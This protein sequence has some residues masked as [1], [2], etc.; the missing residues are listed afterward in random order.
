M[1]IDSDHIISLLEKEIE[2]LPERKNEC[3]QHLFE[4]GY[5]PMGIIN[6]VQQINIDKAKKQFINEAKSSGLYPVTE[7]Y[8]TLFEDDDETL[9]NLLRKATDIDEGFI[10]DKLPGDGEINL[11]SRIIHYR[12]DVFGMWDNPID[13]PYSSVVTNPALKIIAD[14]IKG[15]ILEAINHLADIQKLTKH[16]LTIYPIDTFIL[17]FKPLNKIKEEVLKSFRGTGAFRNQLRA[18]FGE[19]N[20]FFKFLKG[21][22]FN[23]QSKNI[24]FGFLDNECNNSLKQ[25]L[26]RLIQ[27]HQWQDGF[28]DGLLDSDIGEL[29]LQSFIDAVEVYNKT[30]ENDI[31]IQRVITHVGEGYFLFN[32]LFFLRE[33]MIEEVHDKVA[34]D[35]ID[36]ET[37]L[38]NSLLKNLYQSPEDRIV[39]FQ[40]GLE[41]LKNDIFNDS[42]AEPTEKKGLLK[43]IYFGFKRLIRKIAKI[44]KNV[45]NWIIDIAKKVWKVL[46]AVFGSFFEKLKQGIKAFIDGIKFLFGRREIITKDEDSVIASRMRIDGDSFTIA[47]GDIKSSLKKHLG[48]WDYGISSLRFSMAIV[49]GVLKIII[50]AISIISWPLILITIVK[51][52]KNI[53]EAYTEFQAISI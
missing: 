10:F 21:E 53:T 40:S 16:L 38:V 34:E 50:N 45:F 37:F 14:F 51:V 46:K 47:L 9:T 49:G 41:K 8:K 15:S 22:I 13:R 52:Y 6:S 25:F 42:I 11:V 33:Y 1:S 7:I 4:L 36:P 26:I 44:V 17:T 3:L 20:E 30:D 35:D 48:K 27:V 19:R 23:R 32:S 18:D 2:T 39:A 24:D 12:L 5:I 28:Y 29:S 31:K 43:R